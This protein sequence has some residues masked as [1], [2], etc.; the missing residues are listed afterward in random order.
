MHGVGYVAKVEI[1]NGTTLVNDTCFLD[2]F[3]DY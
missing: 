2:A 1:G 3:E